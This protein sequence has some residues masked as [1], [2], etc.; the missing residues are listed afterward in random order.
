M[1]KHSVEATI[2]IP[3]LSKSASEFVIK[4]DGQVLGTLSLS[5]GGIEYRPAKHKNPVKLNW[6]SFDELLRR[7]QK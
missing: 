6:E 2:N 1:A 3:T 4:A 7:Q 5:K